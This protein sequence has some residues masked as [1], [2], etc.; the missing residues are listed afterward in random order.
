MC[1]A[2]IMGWILTLHNTALRCITHML[3]LYFVLFVI[4]VLV[5]YAKYGRYYAKGMQTYVQMNNC[6]NTTFT[7][8][9][10]RESHYGSIITEYAELREAIRDQNITD[11]F[12]EFSDVV[13]SY[14]RYL[15]IEYVPERYY[16]STAI[17]LPLFY[18]CVPVGIKLANRY[19]QYGCIRNHKNH[20]NTA[21][22]CNHT[23]KN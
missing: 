6:A 15:I 7:Q 2:N 9:H 19:K 1:S 14:A 16:C 3:L 10:A 5:L 11:I 13:H 8:K 23:A 20:N 22:N 18:L 4:P 21:H 17:W 12:L